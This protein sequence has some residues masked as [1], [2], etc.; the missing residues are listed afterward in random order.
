[1]IGLPPPRTAAA[2]SATVAGLLLAGCGAGGAS[3]SAHGP[4]SGPTG[5]TTST[6]MA[7]QGTPGTTSPVTPRPSTTG[8]PTGSARS[9]TGPVGPGGIVST[10]TTGTTGTTVPPAPASPPGPST[11]VPPHPPVGSGAYG[12]V[13]AGPTCPVERPDQPCPPRPV[14]AEIDA[15]DASGSTVASTTSDSSGRYGLRLTPGAYTLVVVIPSGFPRCPETPVTVP[16]GAPTRA[17][18]SCDTGIR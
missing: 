14:S 11:T 7:G 12:F 16:S 15:R 5:S 17:D 13:T 2:W 8:T 9:G 3:V 6:V 10:G 18:I 1:V 4:V